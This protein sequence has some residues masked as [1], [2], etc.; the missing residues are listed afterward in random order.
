MAQ[1][2]IRAPRSPQINFRGGMIVLD[3]F[4]ETDIYAN[5]GYESHFLLTADMV[6]SLYVLRVTV[7]NIQSYEF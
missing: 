4:L 6:W 7:E 3:V 5:Y 2:N 1:L